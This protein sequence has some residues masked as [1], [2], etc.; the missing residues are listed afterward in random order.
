MEARLA[1][2]GYPEAW[3]ARAAAAVAM[4][5][6][7][8]AAAAM[9]VAASTAVAMVAAAAVSAVGSSAA[10]VVYYSVVLAVYCLAALAVAATAE[11][12][13]LL[14]V[15]E[16]SPLP[17]PPLDHRHRLLPIVSS[18]GPMMSACSCQSQ[19]QRVLSSQ[20]QRVYSYL[21]Q[22][23]TCRLFCMHATGKPT[24]CFKLR[25]AAYRDL[26]N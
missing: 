26:R 16:A 13:V 18:T 1:A 9:V 6:A 4:V 15:A 17:S 20:Q 2:V 19:Q 12:G 8:A 25:E 5:V 24:I 23:I 11:R 7:A 22:P 14:L 10:L 3:A 21:V